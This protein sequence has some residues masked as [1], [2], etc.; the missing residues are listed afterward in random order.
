MAE[1]WRHRL[2]V[3]LST[4]AAVAAVSIAWEA[5][6]PAAP[7]APASPTSA[8]ALRPVNSLS[9]TTRYASYPSMLGNV[10]SPC[11]PHLVPFGLYG[12]SLF[13]D[14][15]TP[16][17]PVV[18]PNGN[19]VQDL[20]ELGSRYGPQPTELREV[21]PGGQTVWQLPQAAGTSF[22]ATGRVAVTAGAHVHIVDLQS[23]KVTT[24]PVSNPGSVQV[25]TVGSL[26][27][28]VAYPGGASVPYGP[29]IV[30]VY[31]ATGQLVAR[32]SLGQKDRQS[33]YVSLVSGAREAYITT[34]TSVGGDA[35]LYRLTQS[36]RFLPVVGLAQAAD[37][38]VVAVS[39][40]LVFV[41]TPGLSDDS[42]LAYRIRHDR[43]HLVWQRSVPQAPLAFSAAEI[44]AGGS[45]IDMFD[46]RTGRRLRTFGGLADSWSPL[47]FGPF[48]LLALET[49]P[50]PDY[51][52]V[53]CP[54]CPSGP[55]SH[56]ILFS[57]TGRVVWNA[58]LSPGP[59]DQ[60]AWVYHLGPDY[61]LVD[62]A[63]QG[64]AVAWGP[65]WP[66]T[67]SSLA[68]ATFLP[69]GVPPLPPAAAAGYALFYD[70]QEIGPG[71]PFVVTAAQA[72]VPQTLTLTTVNAKGQP[73]ASR[74]P[75]DLVPTDNGG[76][77]SF[78]L[79]SQGT[80]PLP[81][82]S[83][84]VPV[85][86]VNAKAG[87][88]NLSAAPYWWQIATLV[89]ERQGALLLPPA[90][91]A[92]TSVTVVVN[93]TDP[94]GIPLPLPPG[95]WIEIDAEAGSDVTG[96]T[97]VPATP[98]PNGTYRATF[99][100]GRLSGQVQFVAWMKGYSGGPANLGES[101]PIPV[102]ASGAPG[103]AVA[104][105]AGSPVL[106]VSAPP[107]GITPLGYAVYAVTTGGAL[108]APLAALPG[109]QEES[110]PLAALPGGRPSGDLAVTA[111]YSDRVQG[112][113]STPV[114]VPR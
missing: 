83:T 27:I 92:G 5:P 81:Q 56:L 58:P 33:P 62:A 74:G 68:L 98:G 23:R 42:L 24:V 113:E 30:S 40:G 101:L 48:G 2:R 34:A 38:R 57:P 71:H 106:R 54:P 32:R 8:C 79:D 47:A 49:P 76:G 1:P 100:L 65:E 19:A 46:L 112:P 108:V 60:T 9:I 13:P 78:S 93:W 25:G 55:A 22:S 18:L 12:A 53:S 64:M 21:T 109:G 44:A 77:G 6:V 10:P 75:V 43:A 31:S 89:N 111:L 104:A 51:N 84:G 107:A 29:V 59:L 70:G 99:R 17:P 85:T 69:A 103:V 4:L 45:P 114:A 50:Q 90:M 63:L 16:P 88:Y 95:G 37:G 35:S 36:G 86:Y 87:T 94:N 28:V 66:I 52:G 11:E 41:V 96:R 73:V 82:G 14:G 39:R 20:F 97:N 105:A 110:L 80:V 3:P 102:A 91:Y 67:T 15:S 7:A 26:A 61:L 72:G